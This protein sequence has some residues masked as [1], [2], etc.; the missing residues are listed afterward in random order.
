M[1]IHQIISP[2]D[3]SIVAERELATPGNVEEILTNAE[4]ARRLWATT[5]IGRRIEIVEAMIRH[6]EVNVV[7]IAREITLQMGRPIRYTPN[8]I[9][10]GA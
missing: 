5:A 3:G 8:E 6:L 10:R 1:T 2:V 4:K 9:L 7:D